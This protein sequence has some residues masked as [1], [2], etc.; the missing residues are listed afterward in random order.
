MKKTFL[1]VLILA[2]CFISSFSQ[3]MNYQKFGIGYIAPDKDIAPLNINFPY[4]EFVLYDRPNGNKIGKIYKK[5][6][7][8][9]VYSFTTN[10]KIFRI[11]NEDMVEFTGKAY[12]MKY[13]E[14]KDNFLKVMVNSHSGGCWISMKELAYLRIVYQSWSDYIQSKKEGFY[15]AVD[16][17][18]NLRE[19]PDAKSKK[20]DLMKG[21][22]YLITLSGQM[23]GLW[24]EVNVKKYGS[25]PCKVKD[26]SQMKPLRELKGWIKAVDDAGIP[27]IW[28][29][30]EGCE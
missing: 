7:L 9:L 14:A 13:F 12:C 18:L 2:G 21:D 27:N 25:R 15:P 10:N 20:V 22:E 23:D 24:A 3:N 1:T 6:W 30:T 16:I 28:F 29:H 17:G 19:K 5:D 26:V 8:N 4:A 11:K